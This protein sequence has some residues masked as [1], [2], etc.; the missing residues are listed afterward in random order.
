MVVVGIFFVL[1]TNLWVSVESGGVQVQ[2]FKNFYL[3]S[4]LAPVET[5]TMENYELVQNKL[6]LQI[7][8]THVVLVY[9]SSWVAF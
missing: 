6:L 8:F 2:R 5:T 7:L 1:A 9:V 4:S 3:S